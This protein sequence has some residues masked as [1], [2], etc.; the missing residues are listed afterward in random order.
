[1]K[2]DDYRANGHQEVRSRYSSRNM[3]ELF[4][5]ES[6]FNHDFA[7]PAFEPPRCRQSLTEF[8]EAQTYGKVAEQ[9]PET[10]EQRVDSLPLDEQ[11]DREMLNSNSFPRDSSTSL[12]TYKLLMSKEDSDVL[13]AETESPELESNALVKC[14]L[15]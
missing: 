11:M 14:K 8:V 12:P 5:N 1:M 9:L 10:D 6:N 13:M 3:D 15:T 4:M 2:L 7:I